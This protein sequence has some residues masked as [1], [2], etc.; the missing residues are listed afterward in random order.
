MKK[1]EYLSFR[2]DPQTKETLKKLAD[3]KK[4]ST[5]QLV[6]EIVQDWLKQHTESSSN[7]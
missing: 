5:S 1:S 4:W 7:D 6:E 3:E 2:I